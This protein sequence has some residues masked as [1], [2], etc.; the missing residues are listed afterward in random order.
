MSVQNYYISPHGHCLLDEA[1]EWQKAWL[2]KINSFRNLTEYIQGESYSVRLQAKRIGF[3][4]FYCA[5]DYGNRR[6]AL[7]AAFD[8][9]N[10][11]PNEAFFSERCNRL[12]PQSI[13]QTMCKGAPVWA[14]HKSYEGKKASRNLHIEHYGEDYAIEKAILIMKAMFQSILKF[15]DVTMWRHV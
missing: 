12:M 13:T 6:N 1:I 14:I 11:L 9:R 7:Q 2:F 8:A 5:T 3:E 15:N 4:H 10:Q